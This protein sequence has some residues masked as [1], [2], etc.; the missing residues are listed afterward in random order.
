MTIWPLYCC[1]LHQGWIVII[2]YGH[3]TVWY[4]G[5]HCIIYVITKE[6]A[7]AYIYLFCQKREHSTWPWNKVRRSSKVILFTLVVICCP[8]K[9]SLKFCPCSAHIM[10]YI[11]SQ[12][13]TTSNVEMTAERWCLSDVNDLSTSLQVTVYFS[14]YP[15][16]RVLF[17]IIS[18]CLPKGTISLQKAAK[19]YH[20]LGT[21]FQG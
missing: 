1:I 19:K 14:A 7:F 6:A 10:L 15:K 12:K 20:N 17:D 4:P 8:S 18:P 16:V 2:I 5:C 13:C 3:Y 11:V 9:L 21:T